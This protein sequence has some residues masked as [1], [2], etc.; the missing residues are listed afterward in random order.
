MYSVVCKEPVQHDNF[1]TQ[2][3]I[4]SVMK[5]DPKVDDEDAPDTQT[6]VEDYGDYEDTLP[7]DPK[8][9]QKALI[10][11]YTD[12][13]P[14]YH[15]MN[16]ALREDDLSKMKIFGAFIKELQEAFLTDQID[17]ILTPFR[18]TV[19]RGI[20]VP[21][22]DKALKD[23]QPNKDFVWSAFTSTTTQKDV[24]LDFGNIVFEIRCDPPEGFYKDKIYEYAP[25]NIQAFS[26]FPDEEEI[27]FPPNVK[28]RVQSVQMPSAQNGLPSPLVICDCTAF[29][30]VD[31]HLNEFKPKTFA[32]DTAKP[33]KKAKQKEPPT[34]AGESPERPG[35]PQARKKLGNSKSAP[36]LQGSGKN[37]SSP[38]PGTSPK[39]NAFLRRYQDDLNL[40]RMR[41][42]YEEKHRKQPFTYQTGRET[43]YDQ[44]W[45]N[46][47]F[48][49]QERPGL[50]LLYTWPSN[51]QARL[52][53]KIES[54]A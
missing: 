17:Q 26:I 43:N 3:F 34:A 25:A 45:G 19:W 6:I 44:G 8:D 27:L 32:N 36:N 12:E 48:L 41:R 23:Y 38:K 18:G 4:A 40:R 28:F 31:G 51:P 49:P 7:K 9:R 5:K 2:N 47:E 15:E 16:A 52:R 33:G 20:T 46:L 53:T 39:P 24:A 42:H 35:N 54:P 14:L 30:A 29:D 11:L 10:R 37:T 22:L 50:T 21:D 13:T 1:P